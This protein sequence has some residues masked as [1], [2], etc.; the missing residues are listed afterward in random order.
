MIGEIIAHYKVTAKLGA[1]GMGEVYRATDSK[2]GRDVALKV[3]PEAFASDAQRMQRFQREA[4]VLASL[5]HPH[6]AAIYG[7][8]EQRGAAS[9]AP[10]RALVMELVEGPTL[11]ER[12]ARGAIP[13]EE[14]LPIARQVAEALEYAHE[15]GIVHRDLKP[16]NIKLTRDGHVKVLDF[17]LAKALAEDAASSLDLANSPRLSVAAT[18]AG[19]ILGTAAYMSPEQARGKSVDRRAD[20]WAFGVVLFEMLSGKQIFS[21]ETASDSMAAVITREPEWGALPTGTPGQLR[22]LLQRCLEKDPRQRLQA[23]GEARI[24]I[25]RGMADPQADAMGAAAGAGAAPQ[26]SWMRTLPWAVAGAL[27]LMAAWATWKVASLP[28]E[29]PRV[30]Q[31]FVVGLPKGQVVY[32]PQPGIAISPD[33]KH[34]VYLASRLDGAGWQLHLRAMDQLDAVPIGDEDAG[35]P[36]FSPDGQWI[37]YFAGGK[38]KKVSIQGGP[39]VT[40][41]DAGQGRGGSWAGNTIV[42][43]PNPEAGLWRVSADGGQAEAIKVSGE[44]R[45]DQARWPQILSDGDTVLFT[46]QMTGGT[47][48]FALSA[49]RLSSGEVKQHVVD[50]SSARYVES[51]HLVFLREG[52]LYAAPFD[53]KRL[54]LAGPAVPVVQDVTMDQTTHAGYY[55]VARD[56]TLVYLSSASRA[57]DE[58]SVVMV[59]RKGTEKPLSAPSRPYANIR[60]SPDGSQLAARVAA[61]NVDVWSYSLKRGSLSRLTF[62][63]DEDENPVW[64]PDGRRIVYSATRENGQRAL[65]RK[66]ADGSGE[67]E[68]LWQGGTHTHTTSVSPDQRWLLYADYDGTTRGDMWVLPLEGERKPQPFL[69]TPFNEYDGRFSPNGN[70][71]AYTSDESGKNQVYVQAFPGPGGKWQVS[72]EGGD[73]PVWAPNGKE[74]FF[75]NGSRFMVVSIAT[76]PTFSA[77]SPRL[78]FEGPYAVNPRREAQYDVFPDGQNFA[79]LKGPIAAVGAGQYFVVTNWT[80]ELKRLAPLKK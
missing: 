35:W 16:A 31:R 68:V 60:L 79:M 15:R 12:I 51:G 71:V 78:L 54:E 57:T 70:W 9:S 39:S 18:R 41:A 26:S 61:T 38:L 64:M 24:A 28:A 42:Y 22:Q 46:S 59:D 73:S 2:L 10:T 40:L 33:G 4:Q 37:A 44:V 53:V 36:F 74:L 8:E 66:N 20:I 67:E 58:T 80:E 52:T 29:A 32:G 77:A 50:G 47:I 25:E 75:R 62:Q 6:I 48:D 69:K 3:L 17:G 1:G 5:N 65:M 13:L 43:V 45:L 27:A 23:I 56:G 55:S 19:M 14:A 21:G 34:V 7:L 49:L 72:S 11:A 30:T 63:P 76:V